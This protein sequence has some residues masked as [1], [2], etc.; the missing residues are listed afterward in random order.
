MRMKKGGEK[1]QRERLEKSNQSREK[2]HKTESTNQTVLIMSTKEN[3][4]NSR[5]IIVNSGEDERKN[6]KREEG[7]GGGCG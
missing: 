6:I 5:R 7:S 2:K 4:E 3:L 1:G